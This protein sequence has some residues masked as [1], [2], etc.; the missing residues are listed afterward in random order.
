MQA[1]SSHIF[2]GCQEAGGN[3]VDCTVVE[4]AAS[5]VKAA[6]L[7]VCSVLLFGILILASRICLWQ[8]ELLINMKK[9]IYKELHNMT[10]KELMKLQNGSD[11]RALP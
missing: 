7:L 2:A 8:I 3:P 9:Y 4:D 1:G 11:V 10:E 6:K 5:G